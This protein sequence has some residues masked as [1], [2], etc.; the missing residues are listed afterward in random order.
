MEEIGKGKKLGL[1][2]MAKLKGGW[3]M[4]GT[5]ACHICGTRPGSQSKMDQDWFY[6]WMTGDPNPPAI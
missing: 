4:C 2:E 6:Y 1:K 5:N 3:G